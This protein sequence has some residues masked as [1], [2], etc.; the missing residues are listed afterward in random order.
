MALKTRNKVSAAFSMSSMTDIVFLL[1][2]FFM[3]TS[4][5]ISPNA[6]KL[7]L[8]KSSNQ[9]AAKPITTVSIDKN[10]NFYLE[11]TPVPFSQLEHKLQRKLARE[12]DPTISLHVDKSVP[13]E[14]VVKVM[15]IAK[16]NKYKLILATRAK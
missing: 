15:N 6:L 8:P 11:T 4:T 2:I 5:L 7:L 1:L 16:D 3:V 9:T 10:F 12:E 14:Q 13:M